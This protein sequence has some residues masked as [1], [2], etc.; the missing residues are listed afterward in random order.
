MQWDAG[1][2]VCWRTV[3]SAAGRQPLPT[4]Q[5]GLEALWFWEGNAGSPKTLGTTLTV[6]GG[7]SRL[8]PTV[9]W[10]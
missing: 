8:F 4:C 2:W 3:S 1:L 5:V 7:S 9:Q 10:A 6:R